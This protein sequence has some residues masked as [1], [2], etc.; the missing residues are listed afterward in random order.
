MDGFDTDTNVIIM[1]ATNR[2]DILD[3]ALLRPGRFDRRV[4]LDRPDV[5]GREAILK[6]H[7]KGKP[8]APAIDLS[9][10]ARATPGFVGADIEN[11]V[12]EAA[13]LAARRNKKVIE[14]E[15]F[16]EAIE[17]VIAGPERKSR[18]INAEE[19]QIIAYHEAGHAV[20]IFLSG[21]QQ[22][23]VDILPQVLDNGD[24]IMGSDYMDTGHLDIT[25]LDNDHIAVQRFSKARK[26]ITIYL[27]GEISERKYSHMVSKLSG[28][29]IQMVDVI[30]KEEIVEE[31]R[32]LFLKNC[33]AV[34]LQIINDYWPAIVAL[35]ETLYKEKRI[36]AAMV[37]WVVEETIPPEVIE[38][39]ENQYWSTDSLR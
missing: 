25:G 28:S 36:P 7:V 10:I 14:Q 38:V 30:L 35:A 19:K 4:V 8:L 1:A 3:P 12:N 26:V 15:E 9:L 22:Q 5:K 33:H 17:R 24:I 20:A 16:E 23:D 32:E 11:L 21:F 34:S 2:P 39:T 37:K 18:L 31:Q 27:C 13:I 29:D 6:V